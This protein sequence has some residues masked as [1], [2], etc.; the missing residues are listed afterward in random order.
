MSDDLPPGFWTVHADLPRQGPG[1]LASL[2]RALQ[3]A[4]VRPEW[5]GFDAGCGPGADLPG[6]SVRLA[7]VTACDLYA[8]FVA[9]AQALN[10]PNV[11]LYTGS[12]TDIAQHAPDAGF[13][14]VWCAGALYFLGVEDG[15]RCFKEAL[16]KQ[17]VVCFSEPCL[18]AESTPEIE[19]FWGG[20]PTVDQAGIADQVARAGFEVID[21][22]PLPDVAWEAYF[23]PMET[24]L[25]MLRGQDP[26]ADLQDAIQEA[27]VEIARWRRLRRDTGYLM[28]TARVV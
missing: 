13:D 18:F 9:Q 20:Y 24:R 4:G 27:E 12:M 7:H 28:V 10:L 17:G 22:F 16:T 19:S 21:A 8:P 11:T 1:D 15:L 26:D 5:R 6:L 3:S 2:N 25:A 14:L 23:A